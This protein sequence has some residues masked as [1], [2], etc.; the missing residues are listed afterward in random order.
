MEQQNNNPL[1]R[2]EKS[3]G[4]ALL[5]NDQ[6]EIRVLTNLM[7]NNSLYY[8]AGK[9][10]SAKLFH[11]TKNARVFKVVQK[12]I[13]DGKSVDNI[14]VATELLRKPDPKCY[15]GQE[16][17]TVFS[18]Y[19][20]DVAFAQDLQLLR[21]Y[22]KRRR[23]WFLGQS[24]IRTGVDMSV[25]PEWGM[26][27]IDKFMSEDDDEEDGPV[28]MKQANE[29]MMQRV[30]A[31]IKGS[32]DTMI[33]T[34]FSYLD[35]RGGA[36]TDDFDIIAADS[37]M[38]KTALA[39]NFA[40]SGAKA[41]KPVMVYSME[42]TAPQLAARINAREAETSSSIIQY[43]KLERWQYRNLQNAVEKSNELPIYFDD[44]STTSVD[45]IIASVRLNVRKLG[46]KLVI[47]DYLQILS[48]VG[49]VKN[50]EA[51][52][53]ETSRK[54]KNLAKE[55]HICILA[56]SQLAR[57]MQDP[58]P[59]L[60]RLR[61]SGQTVEAADNVLMIWRPEMYNETSYKDCNAPVTGTAE[62]IIGKGRNIG[63]GSFVVHFDPKLT[64]FYDI[65]PEE[66][67]N[68]NIAAE[69]SKVE[70]KKDEGIPDPLPPQ[71]EQSL[72]FQYKVKK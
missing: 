28:S 26:K 72:P 21:E 2:D 51:F 32:S 59:T 37:S 35:E 33:P 3:T 71:K 54:F 22:A 58:R 70:E 41:K 42:M 60:S 11:D 43:K 23:M 40:V 63:T 44:K 61:G 24:L 31:N 30:D 16:I 50:Q 9:L 47:V 38:G 34:G 57:N 14:Y 46:I 69:T 49:Q 62:I 67:K 25:T 27:E 53:G 8:Q 15:K 19:I 39:M 66:W 56:L 12:G 48:A 64:Y 18:E 6:I 1:P 65:S 7:Y 36:Q 29:M 52:L 20:S 17:L 68:W 4:S 10:L 5:F 55:L 13:I 45:A